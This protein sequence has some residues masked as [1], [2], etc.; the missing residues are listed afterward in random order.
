MRWISLWW[1]LII[2]TCWRLKLRVKTGW[3]L[4]HHLRLLVGN[5]HLITI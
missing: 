4:I 5:V 2:L 1:R 3:G